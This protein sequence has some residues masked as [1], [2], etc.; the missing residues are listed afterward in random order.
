MSAAMK[1]HLLQ[2]LDKAGSLEYTKAALRDLQEE[3]MTELEEV[4]RLFGRKNWILR[5]LLM[6]LKI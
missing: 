2:L 3:I 4:E 5:L 1:S 6:G